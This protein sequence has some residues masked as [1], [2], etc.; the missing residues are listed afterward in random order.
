MYT[1]NIIEGYHR[2]LR[3]ATKG[4]GIF[5]SDEA[6]TKVLYLATREWWAS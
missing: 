1:T 2:Q 4:K 6:L 3:K 5:P